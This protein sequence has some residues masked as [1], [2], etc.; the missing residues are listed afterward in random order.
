MKETVD[1]AGSMVDLQR[2]RLDLDLFAVVENLRQIE[3]LSTASL[4]SDEFRNAILSIVSKD[5]R[6]RSVRVLDRSGEELLLAQSGPENREL[7]EAALDTGSGGG[8]SLDKEFL[9]ELRELP[10]NE[11]LVSEFSTV[12][13]AGSREPTVFIGTGLFFPSGARA[14][15]LVAD[16]FAD[17]LLDNMIGGSLEQEPDLFIVSPDG[18]WIYDSRGDDPWAVLLSKEQSTWIV[19]EF[20]EV[21]RSMIT[22]GEGAHS[23]NEVWVFRDHVP[24]ETALDQGLGVL[25]PGEDPVEGIS[26]R[27]FFILKKI[28]SGPA[29]RET[30]MA[31]IPILV[32]FALALALIIPALLRKR[33]ALELSEQSA[34]DLRE[35]GLRT[36][37][38]MEAAR[39]SEWRI[40]LDREIVETDKR[41]MGMLLLG[42]G[43]SIHT[44]KDWENRIHPNDRRKLLDQLEPL[45]K[46]GMGTFSVRH[47]MRRGDDT[48]G[49]YRFR[50]AVRKDEIEA[51]KFILGAYIDLTDGVLREAELHRLEMAT[52]QSLSGIAI[53]DREGVLEWA[54]P[55]FQGRAERRSMDLNGR[56]IWDLLPLTFDAIDQEK[57]VVQNAILKGEEFSLTISVHL[58]GED[59]SWRRITG[60]PVLDEGG[61]PANFVVIETDISREKRAEADLRKSESLLMESQRLAEI[62]SWEMDLQEGSLYWSNE[63]YRIFGVNPDQV[64]DVT[65]TLGFFQENDATEI[66]KLIDQAVESG[67][68]FEGEYEVKGSDR[69]EKWVFLR[70]LALREGGVTSKVFGVIQDISSRKD[71]EA[72]LLR[73]K[74]EA[75]RLNDQLAEALDKARESEK[76]AEEASDAKSAFL[77]MVSHEIRNPL[78][79]VIG[80]TALLRETDLDHSQEDYV[81]TIHNSGS[82]LLMLLDDILDFSRLEHGKIEF[83]QN[84]FS[85]EIAVEESVALF[86]TILAQKDLDYSLWIDPEVPEFVVGDITRIKQILFN[87][88]GNAVKFTE[89]GSIT[90][91]VGLRERLPNDRCLIHFTVTDTGIGIPK[92]R[93]DRVFQTFSQVDASI[94]RK[95]GG[96]GLGL[97]ITKELSQR[98]GGDTRCESEKGKGSTF[99]VVLPFPAFFEKEGFHE[100]RLGGE[101]ICFFDLPTRRK[102]F[103]SCLNSRGIKVELVETADDF[104]SAVERVGQDCWIFLDE[105]Y[106]DNAELAN[107]L[108]DWNRSSR[109]VGVVGIQNEGKELPV[110]AVRLARPVSK[111]RIY[112]FLDGEESPKKTESDEGGDDEF[113]QFQENEIKILVAEDN[114]VNQKV[115]RLL[116]KRMGYGCEVVE[117]G[118]LAVE[119]ATSKEFD[120]IFMD[121]QMP[122]MD[123]ME[124]AS[125]II[126]SVPEE[127][128]P[129]IIALTAG[130]TRDNREEAIKAGMNG[131]LTK[132]VQPKDLEAALERV[133]AQIENRKE[134]RA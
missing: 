108:S 67:Q 39:I 122:E 90:V 106:L 32:I 101:A 15:Y 117:N 98:M 5:Q 83:E 17:H 87:L 9:E 79:G 113:L 45:W 89:T 54:N 126:D 63:T 110:P 38:A 104:L 3:F 20:P 64:P 97:A 48:W 131:Y 85:I 22:T 47:R 58:P 23:G 10:E 102:H 127:K 69:R 88:I 65:M 128:R 91:E 96:S 11:I 59:S 62:G 94:S 73:S 75:E 77:S 2:V 52:R 55:S 56:K 95:F 80:M 8:S 76:K 19:D 34:R 27:P 72:A 112:S 29:W 1:E 119:R 103:K 114:P 61:V 92:D 14:G 116:L 70:G 84:R 44:V 81:E 33:E 124:A 31:L 99:E 57:E 41:M 133:A 16:L 66:R 107:L 24:L 71:Y 130:A 42:P 49:W 115:I 21:W 132:P 7:E 125:R 35:A 82:T 50:G 121:I 36:R 12:E 25:T 53:L 37:M 18:Q 86:S 6:I 100:S 43:E 109:P 123:G 120:A 105:K 60:N 28:S 78:N 68:Q 40:D 51:E 74:E 111:K 129:W 46:E 13:V 118:A 93:Q 4:S 134:Q 30:W 26:A